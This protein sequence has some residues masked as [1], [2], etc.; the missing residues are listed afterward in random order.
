VAG[1]GPSALSIQDIEGDLERDVALAT[2]DEQRTT[3]WASAGPL[4][5]SRNRFAA[6]RSEKGP[7]LWSCEMQEINTSV[8]F[9]TFVE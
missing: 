2:G 4:Q 9:H 6:P 3:S 7:D 8:D 1:S 5:S